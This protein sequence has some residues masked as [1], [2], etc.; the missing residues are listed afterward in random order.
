MRTVIPVILSGGSGTRLWPLSRKERPKQF[1][2]LV[3]DRSLFQETV[4]RSGALQNAV[5]PLIVCNEAHRFLV[6]EQLRE[7][8]TR[9]RAIVLEP[10]GRN[11]APAVSVAAMLAERSAESGSDAMLAV[12]PAD[13]VITSRPAFVSAVSAAVEAAE[14]GHLAT[15]GVVP[16]RPETGYGYILRGT[17]RRR[18]SDLE[19]FVEKPDLATAKGYVAS[20]RHLWNSGMFVFRAGAYLTELARHAPRIIEATKRAVDEATTDSDFTRLG[21]AFADCPSD[22]ID[23]AVMEKTDKA[24]VVSLDAGWND[25]GSW[26]ALHDVLD[27]DAAGN[28]LRGDVLAERCRRSYI[29]ANSRPI[30]ALGLEGVVIVETADSLLV[31]SRD[32]AQNVK[33]V[34][35]YFAKRIRG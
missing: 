12:F 8:G 28:V 23:Y 27:K 24:V 35:D 6:A 31:M 4:L 15:F 5:S 32:E 25:V 16:T 13:H 29:S 34:A 1:L 2:P 20:G 14:Q 30:A 7:L 22:S 33:Q 26:S 17:D 11:T 10:I 19:R 18:W 3:G 21:A 9:A